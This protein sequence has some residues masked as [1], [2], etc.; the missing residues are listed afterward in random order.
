MAEPE[1]A[2]HPSPAAPAAEPA[3]NGADHEAFI[4]KGSDTIWEGMGIDKAEPADEPD[5]E[6]AARTQEQA[7]PLAEPDAAAASAAKPIEPAAPQPKAPPK[8]W[9]KEKHE[10]WSKLATVPDAQDY[11]EQREKQM[12]DGIEQ[13]KEGAH[14]AKQMRDVMTPYKPIL[15]AQGVDEPQAVQYLLNAHYQLTQGSNEARM[16]AFNRLGVNLGLIK[17][18]APVDENGDPV[19]VDPAVQKLQGEVES[20]KSALTERD[21]AAYEAERARKETEVNAFASDATHPYF[22]ELH[23][24]MVMMIHGMRAAGQEPVLQDVY[25]RCV[26]ANPV[27]RTKELARL[28]TET[29]AK[30]K[31]NAR[32]DALKARKAAETNIRGRESPRAPTEPTGKMFDDMGEILKEIRSRPTH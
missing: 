1:V 23:Q 24:D 7:Q 27:T 5:V 13:Y 17:A 14:F 4:D 6:A 11:Y 20:V 18:D 2:A 3:S 32:L 21:R 25:E 8:S 28:Q 30:L 9:A 12:L 16:A 26:F 22:D 29:E 15:A 31:E 19:R 10:L